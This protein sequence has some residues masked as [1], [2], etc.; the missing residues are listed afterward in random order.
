MMPSITTMIECSF[1]VKE[2]HRPGSFPR[3]FWEQR[4][5]AG[6]FKNAKSMRWEPAMIRFA[7]STIQFTLLASPDI[8]GAY[9]YGIFQVQHMSCS[10][11]LQS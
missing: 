9:M 5:K 10:V 3:I 2:Q 7:L 1:G 11:P 8:C 4:E 6:Q